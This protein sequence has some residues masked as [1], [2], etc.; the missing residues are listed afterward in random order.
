M[1]VLLILRGW[2]PPISGWHPP[3]TRTV[4]TKVFNTVDFGLQFRR[5]DPPIGE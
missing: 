1:R 5:A 3:R 4:E 2:V